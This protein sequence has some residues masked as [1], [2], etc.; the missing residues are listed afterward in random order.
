MREL[1][2]HQ[3]GLREG[4]E[5]EREARK[6]AEELA[7]DDGKM[8]RIK[9]L[10]SIAQDAVIEAEEAKEDA[11]EATEL[12]LKFEK[13]ADA[14]KLD[15]EHLNGLLKDLKAKQQALKWKYESLQKRVL[16]GGGARLLLP[17]QSYIDNDEFKK[18]YGQE[19]D[20]LKKGELVRSRSQ[21]VWLSV[22]TW[23]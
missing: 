12:A 5:V 7:T 18:M 15:V 13:E 22:L 10:T 19:I 11:E 16:E 17:G 20:D 4:I 2:V 6:M 1:R 3:Q 8:K 23:H 14:W 9:E 21:N